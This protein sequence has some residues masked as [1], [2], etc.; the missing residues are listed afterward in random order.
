MEQATKQSILTSQS[1]QTNPYKP[2]LY[3]GGNALKDE[4][5]QSRYIAPKAA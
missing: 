1:L 5:A 3:R 2:I 4:F